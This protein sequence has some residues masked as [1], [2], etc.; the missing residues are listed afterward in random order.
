MSEFLFAYG[1]LLPG[2]ENEHILAPLNGRWEPG[3]VFGVLHPQGIGAALGWP[4]LILDDGGERVEGQLFQA[5]TLAQNWSLLDEF[6]GPAYRRVLT[7]VNRPD[8][9]VCQAWVYVYND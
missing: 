7:P 6:E 1:S 4:V 8:G 3:H 2:R 5:P 9:S